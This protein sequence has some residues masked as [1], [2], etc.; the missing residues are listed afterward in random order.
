[1]ATFTSSCRALVRAQAHG[2][3]SSA[4]KLITNELRGL[5]VDQLR[6]QGAAY[7]QL[8]EA[9][10]LQDYYSQGGVGADGDELE[11]GVD[12]RS[13]APATAEGGVDDPDSLDEEGAFDSSSASE[14]GG[15]SD[16]A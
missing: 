8:L 1:M 3:G 5:G 6:E 16:D 2:G 4:D 10:A 7:K 15:D 12:E 9:R 13:F 14:W 11:D